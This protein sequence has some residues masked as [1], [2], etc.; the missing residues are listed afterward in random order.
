MTQCRKSG[1]GVFGECELCELEDCC[2]NLQGISRLFSSDK[3]KTF[4]FEEQKLQ[5][6]MEDFQNN[7]FSFVK[8]FHF[9]LKFQNAT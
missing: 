2:R 9:S 7:L 6:N 1:I 8:V 5:L 4:C 3:H